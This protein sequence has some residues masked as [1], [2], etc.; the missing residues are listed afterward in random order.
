VE[1]AYS[2]IVMQRTVNDHTGYMVRTRAKCEM[3]GEISG[4]W[5]ANKP[6]RLYELLHNTRTREI[7]RDRQGYHHLSPTPQPWDT[8]IFAGSRVP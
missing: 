7:T 4:H 8:F 1:Q 3:D 5:F 6:R 2:N